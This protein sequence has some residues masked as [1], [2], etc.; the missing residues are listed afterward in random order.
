MTQSFKTVIPEQVF[1][2]I[3]RCEGVKPTPLP[4]PRRYDKI[5]FHALFVLDQIR[6]PGY[7]SQ[8]RSL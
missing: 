4:E 5:P 2:F 6:P 1:C 3:D 7:S 8:E